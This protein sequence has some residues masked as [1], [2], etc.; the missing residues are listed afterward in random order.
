MSGLFVPLDVE[1]DSDDKM[2][3]AGPMAELLYV[4]GMAF[5]KRTGSDGNIRMLS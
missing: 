4:R 3:E 5:A 2:I 1:Y